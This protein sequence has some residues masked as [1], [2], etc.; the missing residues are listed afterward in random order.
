MNVQVD[1]QELVKLV[2]RANKKVFSEKVE[3]IKS[4]ER[5][6]DSKREWV[7]ISEMDSFYIINVIRKMTSTQKAGDLFN[8]SIFKSLVLNLAE[9][10]EQELEEEEQES[11]RSDYTV[12]KAILTGNNITPR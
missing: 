10:I 2:E 4:L 9:K 7:E 3:Q 11:S 1:L 5:W 8:A 12:R 6:S